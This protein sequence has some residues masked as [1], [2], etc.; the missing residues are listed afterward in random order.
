MKMLDVYS[1]FDVE[2]VRATG[3]RV[4]VKGDNEPYLDFYGGHAVV[5]IGHCHPRWVS[6]VAQQAASLPFYSNSEWRR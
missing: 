6:A 4:F 2:P 5:S 1:L 3:C